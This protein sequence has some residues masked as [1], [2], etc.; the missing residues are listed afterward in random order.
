MKAPRFRYCAYGVGIVSDVPL[1]L[2][3]YADNG[4]GEIEYCSA[5]ASLLP[6]ATVAAAVDAPSDAWHRY[7]SLADG[8]TYVRWEGVGEFLVSPDG[9]AITGRRA[10]GSSAESF[11][12][13]MLGQALSFALVAQ[14]FEPLH[15]TAIVADDRA[16]AFLGESGFGKSSLAAS[17]LGSGY[18]LLTDDLL[19]LHETNGRMLAY[20]GPPRIKLFPKVA[21]RFLCNAL[22][23]GPMNGGTA[24]LILPIDPHRRST[25]PVELRAMYSLAA[26]R[27]ACR[28][29]SVRSETLTPREG[30]IELVKA[31][32]NR[33]L[34]GPER[35]ARQFDVMTRLAD[36]C[37]IRRLMYPRAID[38]LQE[39][40]D[41][42]LTELISG[43]RVVQ[44]S[45]R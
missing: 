14:G 8:A 15:A 23:S 13:Y 44:Y 10:D 41:V 34:V 35:L 30:F 4:L 1:A 3:E 42:V 33:R 6:M 2:P 29:E 9:R 26:P 21:A 28:Q 19:L 12:V 45:S 17:F 18:R 43:A 7:V 25:A 11:Q 38:R 36:R 39:V 27:D 5:T 20:P 22:E 16:V 40:R 37:P 31:T 24:K 32:F